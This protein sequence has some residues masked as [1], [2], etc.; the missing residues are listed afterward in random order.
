MKL[1]AIISLFV[2]LAIATPVVNGDAQAPESQKLEKR[3]MCGGCDNGRKHCLILCMSTPSSV[4]C[5]ITDELKAVHALA[6]P[7]QYYQAPIP[8][9]KRHWGDNGLMLIPLLRYCTFL[10]LAISPTKFLLSSGILV[11]GVELN[12]DRSVE[13][14]LLNIQITSPTYS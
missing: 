13:C 14:V 11:L 10:Y 7:S 5:K 6:R 9:T 3:Q 4:E 8:S 2:A 1:I 12:S